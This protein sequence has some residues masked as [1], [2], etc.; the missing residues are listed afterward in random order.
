MNRTTFARI[1]ILV[2]WLV[3]TICIA[4][5]QKESGQSSLEVLPKF[6]SAESYY[7]LGTVSAQNK[8]YDLAE[9][10]FKKALEYNKNYGEAW[11]NLGLLYARRLDRPDDARRAWNRLLELSPTGEV[12]DEV[13]RQ[14]E[15]LPGTR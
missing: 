15:L 13:R 14:L 5:C 11:G 2:L 3:F 7:N 4:G 9:R 1:T 12:A 10:C 8:K 6:R